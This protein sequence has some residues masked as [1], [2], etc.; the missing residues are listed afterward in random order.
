MTRQP[1]RRMM[2]AGLALLVVFSALGACLLLSPGV[3]AALG[4]TIPADALLQRLEPRG[5]VND[6]AG[7]LDDAG[8]STMEAQLVQ[9]RQQTGAEVAVVTL[10]SLEGGQIDDFA[11]K[12]FEKWGLG[13]EGKDDG[14]LLLVAFED[15]KA[16]IE[17]GYALEAILPDALAGRILDELL[18]PAF[19]RGQYAEGLNRAV[20]RIAGL[21]QDNE[22]APAEAAQA[23]PRPPL[24]SEQIATTLFLAIFVAIGFG[25]IGMSLG[26]LGWLVT[27]QGA[28]RR[29]G[30]PGYFSS[31]L[32]GLLFFLVWGAMFGG[33]PMGM[34]L[35]Q[36]AW[37]S[38]VLWPLAA[39]ASVI[40]AGLGWRSIQKKPQASTSPSRRSGGSAR[41]YGGGWSSGR[42]GGFSSGFGGFGGGGSGG[43]GASGGW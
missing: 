7:L 13:R 15:R 41:T 42:S 38:Y 1:S 28:A 25:G 31:Q 40:G 2:A 24:V 8:R 29:G 12:L 37:A 4:Q 21:I 34:A 14:L 33:I 35:R 43:G 16:R 19:Q 30:Q 39:L 32:I 23:V 17:V 6:W 18:F 11:V 26:G 3:G 9:L 27:S 5:H 22:P 20:Q 10:P 36:A